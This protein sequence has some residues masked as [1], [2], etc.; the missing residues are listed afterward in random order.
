[1]KNNKIKKNGFLIIITIIFFFILFYILETD[2]NINLRIDRVTHEIGSYF[3]KVFL[4][5]TNVINNEITN[6]INLELEKEVNELKKMLELNESKYEIIH[7]SVIKRDNDWYQTLTIDK[8][9]K[10]GI[11]EDMAVISNNNLIGKIIKTTN[12]N[13]IVKLIT[14]SSNDMK[15][16]VIIKT[17]EN[18][19]YGIIDDY[20]ESENLIQVNNILKT[21]NIDIGNKVYTSGLGNL[22]PSGI[23]IGEVVEVKESHLGLN[24]I[25]KIKTD[26]SLDNIRFV[27]VIDRGIW[28]YFL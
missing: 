4:P 13:S 9:E 17:N 2:K 8:G 11:K 26:N 12:S 25:L 5:K 19:F 1:M 20:I 18:E 23:Y 7:A 28:W 14:A 10:D 24:K 27:S 21:A 6:G 16:S 3:E 15:I 22:Y